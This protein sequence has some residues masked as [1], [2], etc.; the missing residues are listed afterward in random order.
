MIG[1]EGEIRRENACEITCND[2]LKGDVGNN[3]I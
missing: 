1:E 2:V 3:G